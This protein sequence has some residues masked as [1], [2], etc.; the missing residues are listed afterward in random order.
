LIFEAYM[1]VAAALV[2]WE[3]VSL[4]ARRSYAVAL[5]PIPELLCIPLVLSFVLLSSMRV[6]F[7][8]PAEVKAN[9]LFRMAENAQSAQGLEAA[10]KVMILIGIVPVTIPLIPLHAWLWGWPI[11]FIHCAYC[12]LLAL[13]LRGCLL[14]NFRKVPFTC[15][16]APA[17]PSGVVWGTSY[18]FVFTIYAYTMAKVERWMFGQTWRMIRCFAVLTAVLIVVEWV[19]RRLLDEDCHLMFEDDIEPAVR[20]LGLGQ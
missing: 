9:W 14:L 3:L 11:A 12:V 2:V 8:R 7:S 20:T 1:G 18:F 16:F 6:V 5:D 4:F 13:I 17:G 15:T 19:R 10:G